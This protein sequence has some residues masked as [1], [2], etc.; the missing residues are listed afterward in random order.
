MFLK[1]LL[2]TSVILLSYHVFFGQSKFFPY[3]TEWKLIDSLMNKKNLPKT[4][5]VEVNKVYAAAK[6]E[7]NEAQWVKAILYRNHLQE[8]E[9][10]NINRLIDDMNQEISGAPAR[11][12]ALLKSVEAEQ[13][14][15][16]WQSNGYRMRNRTTVV[17]DT[18]SDI[19]SWTVSQAEERIRDL[20]LGSLE[21]P[22]LLK[23]IPLENYD[24]VL[25]KG[26]A[27][28]L[29]PTLYDLLAWRALDYFQTDYRFSN[30]RENLAMENP[31]L[32][33]EALFFMHYG[34]KSKDS[35]SNL[36]TA[37]GIYQKLLKFHAK[38]IHL[39]AW[40][41]AD[42]HR[43]QFVYQYANMPEKDSL[44]LNALSRITTQFGTLSVSSQAWYL[45]AQWWN[46]QASAYDPLGDT[47][48]RFDN[49]KAISICEK[50]LNN[51]DSSQGKW[52]CEQLRK[53]IIGKFFSL[54]TE[55]VNI[56]DQPFRIMVTYRNIEQ[57]YFRILRTD[58]AARESFEQNSYDKDNWVKLVRHPY[59]KNFRQAVPVTSDY[60]MHRVELAIEALPLGQYAL[61]ISSDSAFS[62][63][64][65][66]GVNFFINS[67]IAFIA[68]RRD[69]FVVDRLSG[70]PL[71]GIKVKSYLKTYTR[72][73]IDI[74]EKSYLSDL[75]GHFRLFTV[76]GNYGR[77]L[78]FYLG[79][80]YLTTSNLMSYYRETYEDGNEDNDGDKTKKE[81]EVDH[82]KDFI[83]TDRSIYRPGQTVYFKGLMVTRDFMTRKNKI[84]GQHLAK[85]YLQD[86]NGQKIDSLILKSNEFG[87]VHGS[88]HLPL[89]LLNGEFSIMD[90]NT[91]ES[92][93]F[94][95]EEYK[96][97]SFYLEFDSVKSA[98]KIG[99]FIRSTGT[100]MAYA[101]NAI[102]GAKVVWTV[103]RQT[104]Y[105]YP[106]LLRQF[107]SR[108]EM[109]IAH[110]ET[111]TDPSGKFSVG[112]KALPDKTDHRQA[113]PVYN[114]IIS[115]T[116]SDANG[117][118][119]H[120][121]TLLS[122]SYQ[123]FLIKSDLPALSRMQKDSLYQI[124]VTTK[125]AS[126]SFLKELLTVS[127]YSLKEPGRLI[128]E[129]Y[130]KQPDQYV[131]SEPEFIR[132]FPNDEYR[133][134]TDV[135]T[136]KPENKI[137][138]ITDSTNQSGAFPIDRNKLAS[139]LPGW[140]LLEMK[141]KD[142]DGIEI[143]DKKYIDITGNNGTT[144]NVMYNLVPYELINTEPDRTIN[145]QT[146]SGARGIY[147]IRAKQVVVDSATKYSFY[148]FSQGIN[149]SKINIQESDRGGFA[150]VD[151]FVKN[152]R[153][154][155][156]EH[157]VQVPWANKELKITYKTWKDKTL[158][159][160]NEQWKIEIS[161][162]KKDH[163]TAEVLTSMYDI[164]LDQF[165]KHSWT[166]PNLYPVYNRAN[167][168][169]GT[170]NFSDYYT[171]IRPLVE[172]KRVR[173][174]EW[175]YDKMISLTG[176]KY[177][178]LM[179]AVSGV[180]VTDR[181]N[182]TGDVIVVGYSAQ[183]QNKLSADESGAQKDSSN[184]MPELSRK[185]ENIQIR[186]NFNETAF[187]QPDLKTDA[188]GNVEISFTMPEA[189]TRWKWMILAHTKDLAFGYSEK[190]LV[191]QKELM[192]Q[193]N[194]P[195]FFR[196][197]DT[198]LLPVKIAN[199]STQIMS[200]TIQLEWLDAE[201]SQP[202]NQA[203][204]NLKGSQLFTVNAAQSAVVFF[205]A[206]IPANFTKPLLYR[207]TAKT[208]MQGAGYSDGEEAVIPVLSNRLL[209]TESMPINMTGKTDEHF[210][211]EKLLKSG[212]SRSLQ[213]QGL[214]VEYTTNPAWYAVQALPFIMEFPYE[215]AEQTFNRFYANA[216]AANIIK[217]SPLIRS[218]FEKWKSTDTAALMSN[219]EKNQE[220][221]S[222]LLRE[223]PW[224]LEAQSESQQKK[225]IALLFDLV[226]M[227]AALKS[228]LD[229]LSQM[230]SE[231]GGFPWFK[232]GM[233]DRYI[234]QY[235]LSG[236]G[237]LKKL[238]ALPA[239]LQPA[240]DKL[241]TRGMDWL[242]RRMVDDYENRDKSTSAQN[243]GPDQIQYLYM[244]SL[245]SALP[246]PA[247]MDVAINYYKKTCMENWMKQSVYMQGM[248]ALY[249]H[250]A[251][252]EETA[253]EI[254]AS[255][256]ENASFSQ[257]LGMFWKTNQ[258]GYD[259][260]EAPV[261]T[262][263]LLIEVFQ[264]LHGELKD[265]D[266]MK[267]W[268]LQQKHTHHW[269][270]TKATADACYALLL[271]G[272]NWLSSPQSVSIQLGSYKIN[273]DKAEAGTGYF[274]K[275]IP[276]SE[277]HPEMGNIRVV[278]QQNADS[279]ANRQ[280]S[281]VNR[282]QSTANSQL[283][284]AN[285]QPSTPSWGAV[286]WQYFENLDKISSAQT[287]LSIIKNLF[288]EKNSDR[289][290]VLEAIT[291]KN[292]LRPGDKLI[293]RIIVKTDR[294][295]EY[296]HLKDMRAACV[297]PVHVLSGYQW[298]DGLGYYETTKDA[299]TSFFFDRLPKGVHVFEYPVHVTTAGNYSN[300]I[301]TLECMY[302]PE[303][304][305]HS[306]GVRVQVESK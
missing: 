201:T 168:W 2:L 133:N 67:N 42:I 190:E 90:G 89:G 34:F 21:N 3:D 123:T 186:K 68:N 99:D 128:R 304:A 241:V 231:N 276:G 155:T 11:V 189:L 147:L 293:M 124:S 200:G 146:G 74:P 239:D 212:N 60:Q 294:D 114:Y 237:R 81:F 134:E 14:F 47:S 268:L 143:T 220:L 223:T 73:W 246:I 192:V 153:W 79:N 117:E 187:F 278:I 238:N 159:G 283:P 156:S 228:V 103:T 300:G 72:K 126:G 233:D 44:Y 95:V 301:S 152:N 169:E 290:P 198:M 151:V 234:T 217:G 242:D 130:W 122:V 57:L 171:S 157:R 113:Y 110:G 112:F 250:R 178:M 235:I 26:S 154:F 27:R 40:I 53:Q 4:A 15:Q 166:I 205:P 17:A 289:G 188:L 39:D 51:P 101:G 55:R 253:G 302:A 269:P 29:R 28:E 135:K 30:S 172:I 150:L 108:S 203:V 271:G 210:V 251:G 149:N 115:A 84:L 100:A 160:G 65:I 193:T 37:I 1:S 191:T 109:E 288:I 49:V 285:H 260:Q 13:L 59:F 218:V 106:W 219:L 118:S 119:R 284:T 138:E 48:H 167:E 232:G 22:D 62:D 10:R 262:Q 94:S 23:K 96:R 256:K 252:E 282:Q 176:E 259:W 45:Q 299:S 267:Y 35:T 131:M 20:Y 6:S 183:K 197:G 274:K 165:E 281:T 263:S 104:F 58:D 211:F 61:L 111:M 243:P 199:L 33:S 140:Y 297:E 287:Q 272:T 24:P 50:A 129:R 303:F 69:Y 236:I 214:T 12:S 298:Q 102:D 225:N 174:Y 125:N 141:A 41:D 116:I 279:T 161:G 244:R 163:F 83:F 264:E 258:Y 86:V 107:P 175:K 226:K 93:T 56:P 202:V 179:G 63:H 139:L 209:V 164:S 254:L 185:I 306:E 19:E 137:F 145:I 77:T 162:Q 216:L 265:I 195:R 142:H 227:R 92:Q 291:E 88:F 292:L 54:N 7:K 18:T 36:F 177:R 64:A 266:Q 8:T 80:D 221:K 52:N 5:L 196:A 207:V 215:C 70:K 136:W 222:A 229:K 240:L 87:S 31:A 277:V 98:Y 82:M 9:D 85:I 182:V 148:Q 280:P 248:I 273:P 261:E 132:L 296:V 208:D 170:N 71:Q 230:Q 121:S 206:V 173:D 144:Q 275:L 295:L 213:N 43:I 249:L 224:V 32:F 127:M 204:G 120:A 286:Y 194:M 105:P 75:H 247:K 66:I 97:P 78:K 76:E 46:G 181:K 245:F 25:I 91:F 305:A 180:E 38:D 270:T 158:A 16:Y 184:G 257:E 255:I